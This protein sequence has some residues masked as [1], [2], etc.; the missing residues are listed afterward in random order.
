MR[1]WFARRPISEAVKL[2]IQS[3][4]ELERDF[5]R[6]RTPADRVSG[7]ITRF[8]GSIWSVAAHALLFAGWIL[9]N[10]GCVPGV[11]PFDPYPF[12]FLA[13]AVA[14]EAIFL[15]TF[16]LMSQNHLDRQTDRWAHLDLQISLLAEQES[17]K[18]LQMLQRI[19]EYLGLEEAAGDTELKELVEK[20]HVATLVQELEKVREV[21]AEL[22]QEAEKR[23]EPREGSAP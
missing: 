7:A 22:A 17:T 8:A 15:T 14:L 11:R 5:E 16:V 6:R 10:T 2:N 1:N 19:H 18:M 21:E 23:R 3:I 20:T 12:S 4:A 9:V 13:L